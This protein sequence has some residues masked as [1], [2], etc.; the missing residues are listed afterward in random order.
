MSLV[1]H[2]FD[3]GIDFDDVIKSEYDETG[4]FIGF[5]YDINKITA[6]ENSGLKL[7]RKGFVAGNK[8]NVEKTILI[9]VSNLRVD[10]ELKGRYNGIFAP[11]FNLCFLGSPDA[12][13]RVG[14]SFLKV[15]EKGV[16]D[17][18]KSFSVTAGFVGLEVCF[19]FDEEIDLW[20]YP[21]ETVSLSE[22]GV[23]RIYQ[24]TAFL[25]LKNLDL[26][27]SKKTGFNIKF[28]EVKL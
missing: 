7:S 9:G 14:S 27:G 11:E 6:K 28:S 17:N 26:D 8:I 20:H 10:Y 18:I 25:F 1:D 13:I 16:H 22:Q 19:D 3:A 12:A 23:E 2:F 5:P 4:D 15:K 24:G 21:I